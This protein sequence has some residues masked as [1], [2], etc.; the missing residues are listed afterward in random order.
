[1][2]LGFS[3]ARSTAAT[4]A[5]E[6]YILSNPSPLPTS[7]SSQDHRTSPVACHC[8]S[9]RPL[10]GPGSLSN[11]WGGP[12]LPGQ[13]RGTRGPCTSCGWVVDLSLLSFSSLWLRRVHY[14]YVQNRTFDFFHEIQTNRP[15]VAGV[16]GLTTLIHPCLELVSSWYLKVGFSGP[17]M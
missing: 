15:N 2:R 3:L 8:R 14:S 9:W 11:E 4:A 13:C 1:M 16:M 17:T 6:H 10:G 5:R 7:S 12:G